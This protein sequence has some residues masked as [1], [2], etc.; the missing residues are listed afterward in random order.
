MVLPAQEFERA[1]PV[2]T[3]AP[4]ADKLRQAA[5]ILTAQEADPFRV[6]AYR[7]AAD[8]LLACPDD[9]AVIFCARRM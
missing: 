2:R 1:A 5:D 7:R 9:L 4:I 3:N 8:A 6:A